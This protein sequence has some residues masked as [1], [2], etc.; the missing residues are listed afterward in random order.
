MGTEAPIRCML[1]SK[2]CPQGQVF[3]GNDAVQEALEN[4]WQ[5]TPL[6]ADEVAQELDSEVNPAEVE[7]LSV[8]LDQLDEALTA[9]TERADKAE[10]ELERVKQA[11]AG[12][13]SKAQDVKE[14]Q[15]ALSS[16]ADN[17]S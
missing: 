10:T 8:R 5:D 3:V 12:L 1:Y 16:D 14:L 17:E 13:T 15:A 11:V 2:D 6:P 9:A 7:Q 4:G